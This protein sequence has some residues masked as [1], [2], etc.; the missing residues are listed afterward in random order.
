MIT[1]TLR[2][3]FDALRPVVVSVTQISDNSSLIFQLKD[4]SAGLFLA[5]ACSKLRYEVTYFHNSHFQSNPSAWAI[6]ILFII[7]EC[8]H[9]TSPF[10]WAHL[11]LVFTCLMP[12][13]SQNSVNKSDLIYRSLPN[14]QVTGNP[15]LLK[16]DSRLLTF[17][18]VVE[19][20]IS[21]S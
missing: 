21:Y 9:S 13:T 17:S 5:V 12:L 14:L 20:K 16:I 8:F 18:V 6:F 7:D 3:L 2:H 10:P 19:G 4:S 11:C 1:K 15:C